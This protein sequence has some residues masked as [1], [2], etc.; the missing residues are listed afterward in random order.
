MSRMRKARLKRLKIG[1][2]KKKGEKNRCG[3]VRCDT[4]NLVQ[5]T[6]HKRAASMA[7]GAIISRASR[8]TQFVT[9]ASDPLAFC[10]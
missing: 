7:I 2:K 1:G 10:D 3:S 9:T 8:V 4:R 6:S 5:T